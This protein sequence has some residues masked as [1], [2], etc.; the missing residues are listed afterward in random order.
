MHHQPGLLQ[1]GQQPQPLDVAGRPGGAVAAARA[2]RRAARRPRSARRRRRR[3]APPPDHRRTRRARGPAGGRAAARR[4]R[5]P[6]AAGAAATGRPGRRRRVRLRGRDATRD[7]AARSRRCSGG[8][9]GE[10]CRRSAAEA[11][12]HV[13]SART[14][15]AEDLDGQHR[16]T[17]RTERLSRR[18]ADCC[19]RRRAP[20]T[21][22]LGRRAAGRGVHRGRRRG[23]DPQLQPAAATS[24]GRRA[25]P[26]V[27]RARSAAAASPATTQIAT[28]EDQP[29]RRPEVLGDPADQRGTDGRAAHEAHEVQ[30]HDPAA[31]LRVDAELHEA[32]VGHAEH[33]RGGAGRHQQHGERRRSS[34]SGRRRR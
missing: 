2:G 3:P 17:S 7:G 26:G 12:G 1:G 4:R 22:V 15:Q 20:P 21:T 23:A 8:G 13:A 25:A 16:A 14:R 34:A 32:V 24:A 27:P 29:P 30:R 28:A 31:H 6:G 18:T 19:A 5:P 10:R 33:Q 9:H 11:V